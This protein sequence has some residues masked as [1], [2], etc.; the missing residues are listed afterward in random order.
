MMKQIKLA[1]SAFLFCL[2][3]ATSANAQNPFNKSDK[4]VEG[5]LNYSKVTGVDAQYSFNPTIG[6]FIT[7]KFAAGIFG[8]IGKTDGDKVTVVG[9]FGRCYILNIGKQTNVYTQLSV[10]N[11]TVNT[12][13]NTN[14]FGINAGIGANYFISKNLALSANIADL[15]SYTHVGS[16]SSFSVGFDGAQNPLSLAK[17]G[18]LYRF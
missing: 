11:T 2:L 13:V 15:L 17:F 12:G 18:V 6:F 5:T 14:T 3:F 4:F 10:S 1:V 16:T 8:E 7:N 9:G